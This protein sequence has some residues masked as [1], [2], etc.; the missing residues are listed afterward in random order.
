MR[1]DP[2]AMADL[3]LQLNFGAPYHRLAAAMNLTLE[4]TLTCLH[5][6]AAL[7]ALPEHLSTTD[8]AGGLG[9]KL[10]VRPL[11]EARP[12]AERW[13]FTNAFRD[14]IEHV[15]A[16]FEGLR[17]ADALLTLSDRGTFTSEDLTTT[18]MEPAAA[19]D[20]LHFYLKVQELDRRGLI[21]PADAP[22]LISI[23]GARN[24]FVHR[25]G[26]VS[27][28]DVDAQRAS[29]AATGRLRVTWTHP[30]LFAR[31]PE[32]REEGV[33]AGS[34]VEAG[35]TVFLRTEVIERAYAVGER[36][37]ATEEDLIGIWWTVTQFGARASLLLQA[38]AAARGFTFPELQPDVA[39]GH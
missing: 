18:V 6:M 21:P 24:C 39:A 22:H 16:F 19:F 29:D 30:T 28:R 31:G 15:A 37:Q 7:S 14:S 9:L 11:A 1:T 3:T 10:P 35:T 23:N 32:G 34:V 5:G 26:V 13:L 33:R 2:T 20:R 4:H 8:G 36:V 17:E 27:L 25:G 12:D 38:K